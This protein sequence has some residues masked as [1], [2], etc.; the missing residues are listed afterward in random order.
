MTTTGKEPNKNPEIITPN[1]SVDTSNLK[2]YKN[3]LFGPAVTID[4]VSARSEAD[5]SVSKINSNF[6]GVYSALSS[7]DYTYNAEYFITKNTT[8]LDD[9]T[10]TKNYNDAGP[11]ETNPEKNS[12][13]VSATHNGGSVYKIASSS[14]T[15]SDL[16]LASLNQL[17]TGDCIVYGRLAIIPTT[18]NTTGTTFYTP[19]QHSSVNVPLYQSLTFVNQITLKPYCLVKRVVGVKFQLQ[20]IA[21]EQ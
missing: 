18:S 3:I 2:N 12:I 13:P 17:L 6:T 21:M 1:A 16:E 5:D 20:I 10:V 19:W 14:T 15:A 4:G 8:I 9:A 7:S 11:V